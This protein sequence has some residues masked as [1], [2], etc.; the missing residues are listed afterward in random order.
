MQTEGLAT[1]SRLTKDEELESAEDVLCRRMVVPMQ[2]LP[3]KLVIKDT[4][5]L[6]TVNS[7]PDEEMAGKKM[8]PKKIIQF[9]DD[10][11]K[12]ESEN[13]PDSDKKTIRVSL[14]W[15]TKNHWVRKACTTFFQSQTKQIVD[16][17]VIT[18]FAFTSLFMDLN[19]GICRETALLCLPSQAF[20]TFLYLQN[21]WFTVSCFTGRLGSIGIASCGLVFHENAF[22]RS[23]LNTLDLILVVMFWIEPRRLTSLCILRLLRLLQNIS[24][25]QLMKALREVLDILRRSTVVMVAIIGVLLVC[26]FFFNMIANVLLVNPF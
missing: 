19:S 11:S 6:K 1:D 25:W 18:I 22:L 2:I 7:N 21:S 16:T 13:E 9:E 10:S 14:D 24:H 4:Q 8:M 20:S 5:S 26:L 15:L 17:T 3:N 23:R 12:S